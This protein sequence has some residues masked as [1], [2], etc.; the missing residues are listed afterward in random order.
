V[1]RKYQSVSVCLESGRPENLENKMQVSKVL[2][3]G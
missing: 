1:S 2:G 3:G